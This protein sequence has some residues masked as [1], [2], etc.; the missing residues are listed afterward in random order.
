MKDLEIRQ[1]FIWGAGPSAIETITK[2][3]FNTDPDTINTTKLIQQLEDYYMP[4]RNSYHIRGDFFW[5]KEEKIETPEEHWRKLVSL[6]K[7][8]FE[9][10]KQ[11]VISSKRRHKNSMKCAIAKILNQDGRPERYRKLKRMIKNSAKEPRASPRDR[12]CC[13]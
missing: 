12:P 4:E 7:N 10:I 8:E 2:G 13:P 6:K 3:K 1:D 11:D 9:D 5:S